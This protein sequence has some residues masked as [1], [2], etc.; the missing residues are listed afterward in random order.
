MQP[1][2]LNSTAQHPSPTLD[3]QLDCFSV[4]FYSSGRALDQLN[5]NGSIA[6]GLDYCPGSFSASVVGAAVY[7]H[8]DVHQLYR[9][10]YIVST[11]FGD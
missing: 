9:A 10:E 7:R 4:F 3:T 11:R 8:P 1:G 2:W 6:D 5:R